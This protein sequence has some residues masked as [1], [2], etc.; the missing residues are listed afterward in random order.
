V[1]APRVWLQHLLP[2]DWLSARVYAIARS[3]RAW[4]RRP[5]IRW[6]ARTYAVDLAEAERSSLDDYA[7]FNDFFT[8]ALKPGCRPIE[9]DART[10]VAPADGALS[11]FGR[12]EDGRLLQAKGMSYE[13]AALV[14]EDTESVA[15]LRGGS[16]LTVYLAPRDYH[17]V[18]L[19]IDA[20]L[21]RTRYLPGARYSVSLASAAAIERLFC[22]NE[23]A[24]CW[25]D[26]AHGPLAL[27][28]VGALNVSSISTF[29][30]GEIPSGAAREWA[31]P[32]PRP[33]AR[34]AE[35]ARFNLGSTVVLLFARDA[36]DWD[37]SLTVGRALKVGAALG[38]L[39]DA[40]PERP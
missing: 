32:T 33:V 2:K 7:C 24:V 12:I 20:V 19:P 37:P 18:H 38:R 25:F 34:G 17:R 4:V 1:T 40:T 23:R 10:V 14:G 3:R 15:R 31:E 16:F 29:S 21:T 39:R 9:G 11:E 36:L 27:V 35:I 5:L 13:L 28:L 22:R 30:L 8:R 26:S 6:F